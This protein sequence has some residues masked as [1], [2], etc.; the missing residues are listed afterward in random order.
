MIQY[1]ANDDIAKLVAGCEENYSTICKMFHY[2]PE[3][4]NGDCL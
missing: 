4:N 2:Y 1:H 3:Q